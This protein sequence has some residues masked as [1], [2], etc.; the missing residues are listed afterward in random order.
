MRSIRLPF[1]IL[2]L[3]LGIV[4]SVRAGTYSSPILR[5]TAAGGSNGLYCAISNV[6]TT[7]VN[8]TVP[9]LLNFNGVPVAPAFDDCTAKGG[10][11]PAGVTC[12][13]AVMAP[14][15]ARCTVGASSSKVRAILYV[16]LGS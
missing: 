7:P 6:G 16:L 13:V 11:L 10:V 5:I 14:S 3:T 15:T 4:P 9:V 1:L 8:F 12:Q 2:T